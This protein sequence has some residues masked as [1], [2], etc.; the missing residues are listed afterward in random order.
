M[1]SEPE[2]TRHT[3]PGATPRTSTD[4]M[5]ARPPR[6]CGGR[7]RFAGGTV[8]SEPIVCGLDGEPHSQRALQVANHLAMRSGR[9]LE[10][11]HITSAV[12]EPARHDRHERLLC[13]LRS[14][15]GRPDLPL[16]MG[17]GAP[18]HEL[19]CASRR[20]ALIVLG[21]RGQSALVQA[22]RGSVSVAV[23]RTA[24]CP[25][26]V[27]PRRS[28]HDGR[29]ATALDDATV[30]CAVRDE[31]DLASAA[32]A[33]CWAREL[34]LD[35][36]LASVVAPPRMPVAPGI[37]APPPGLIPSTSERLATKGDTLDELA[38]QLA[39]LA[40]GAPRTRVVTG[41]IGPQLRRLAS[42]E[43]AALV[44][45]GPSRRG[46]IREAMAGSPARHLLR[47]RAAP[48]MICPSAEAAVGPAEC[49]E[50]RA[51]ARPA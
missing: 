5:R 48:V 49:R 11:L 35:L 14:D 40:P 21:T 39:P 18:A 41:P 6:R 27:V 22:V 29:L 37:G 44:V 26:I 9:R 33:A 24:A 36:V 28:S 42:L 19:T 12:G 34:G 30:L 20:A 25:V 45:V 3:R 47:R 50:A 51:Q 10:L 43:R 46:R 1:P 15:L 4:V 32:T 2:G 7:V 23:M 16:R 17:T 8:V 38:S 13:T 31:R